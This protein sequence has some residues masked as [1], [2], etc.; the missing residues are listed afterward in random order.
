M[1]KITD[2]KFEIEKTEDM[3]V[4][5]I[6]Y[7]SEKL[8]NDIG[9]EPV[10]QVKN[11]ATLPGI[12][13]YSI[14]MPDIHWGYGFP[15]GGVAAFDYDEGIISPGGVGYDI[16][17]GVRMIRTHLDYDSIKDK[18]DELA[19]SLFNSIPS[20]VGSSGAIVLKKKEL[21]DVLK[22]GAS[23]AIERGFGSISDLDR[24]EDAGNLDFNP[25]TD[26]ISDKAIER[27]LDQLGTLGAG[28]HFL[29]IQKVEN[30]YLPDIAD[31][32]G[33]FKNQ[34]IIMFHTGSRGLGYQIC[35]DYLHLFR[36]VAPKYNI[37]LKD[38]QLISVP[39]KSEEGKKYFN[40][41][42]GAANFAW[43]NRQVISGLI[44][45]SFEKVFKKSG[46]QLGMSVIYDVSHNIARMEEHEIDGK[47]KKL[48]V[49]RKGATR[50]LPKGHP[51]LSSMFKNIGQPV[52]VPGDMGRASF[53]LIARENS[54]EAFYSCAHGAGRMLSR[55]QALK[56]GKNKNIFDELTGQGIIVKVHS[57]KLLA[58]EAPF[59]YKDAED[60][61]K[62]VEKAGLSSRVAKLKPLA[63]VKG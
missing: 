2:Y 39:V 38:Q 28:N 46:A 34:I 48:C 23:W 8:L 43:A 37:K 63:V 52:L 50:A 62:V 27:G 16:N 22:K 55:S 45:K 17:C 21:I 5:G 53:I 54:K 57:K 25:D 26:D 15:I 40:A 20:G 59:A 18:I 35:D 42:S 44:I 30:V 3:N 4:P 61:T 9:N 49:H 36:N 10:T 29:E 47:I 14:A 51:I 31:K 58:E 56:Q 41:M 32:L 6:I 13:K 60:I 33:I 24:I 1:K 7:C 19:N 12:Q 11:V